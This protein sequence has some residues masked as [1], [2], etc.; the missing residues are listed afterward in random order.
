MAAAYLSPGHG[1]AYCVDDRLDMGLLG[2]N[3]VSRLV[4]DHLCGRDVNGFIVVKD[5]LS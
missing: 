1:L 2:R 5:I 3:Q 4:N